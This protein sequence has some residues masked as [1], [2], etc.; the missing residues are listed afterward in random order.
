VV[1]HELGFGW[2]LA[3]EDASTISMGFFI[4]FAG[5]PLEPGRVDYD[6]VA[7]EIALHVNGRLGPHLGSGTTSIVIPALT[8][9]LAAQA[10]R[11]GDV[12]WRAWR[13]DEGA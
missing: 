12:T 13:I 7:P 1:L 3:C 6:A 5:E 9:D 11:S 8:A 4:L 2:D 10:C